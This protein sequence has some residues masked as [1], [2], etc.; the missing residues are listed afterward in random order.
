[1]RYEA[2][3]QSLQSPYFVRHQSERG[4][5][6]RH[7]LVY[8]HPGRLSFPSLDSNNAALGNIGSVDVLIEEEMLA[9]NQ[10]PLG[11]RWGP[12]SLMQDIQEPILQLQGTCT[13]VR[14]ARILYRGMR[15]SDSSW[16]KDANSTFFDIKFRQQEKLNQ[17]S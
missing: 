2:S 12:F 5:R 1:M 13:T 7:S 6:G 11:R 10:S 15:L 9:L 8:C 16:L 14:D 3:N 17:L 4:A